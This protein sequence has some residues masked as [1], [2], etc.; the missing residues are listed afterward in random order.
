MGI[1][2][3]LCMLGYEHSILYIRQSAVEDLG[4]AQCWRGTSA[5]MQNATALFMN[6]VE[7]EFSEVRRISPVLC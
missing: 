6:V 3:V 5:R 4:Y 2:S 1:S 7:E